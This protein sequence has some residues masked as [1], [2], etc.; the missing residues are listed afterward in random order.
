MIG[1]I[2]RIAKTHPFKF[3]M[4]YSLL[5]TAGCD[6][7]VQKVV[8]KREEVDWKRTLAFGSFG[9]FYLGGVQYAIY[10]PLFSR[11]F[12]NAAAFSAKTIAEKAKDIPGIR[13]VCAQVF[14][15]QCV[16]HPLMYFPVFYMLKD[17]ITSEKPDPA[18]AVQ[19]YIG[20]AREDLAALWK[21]WIPSTFINFAFMPM[22]GRIPWVASTSLIWTC[23]LSA[24]RGGADEKLPE[25]EPVF[26]GVDAQTLALVTRWIIGPAPRLDPN[27]AHFLVSVTGDD[28]P[29][30]IKEITRALYTAGGSITTSKMMSLGSEMSITM[31]VECAPD[32]E[33]GVQRALTDKVLTSDLG[34]EIITRRVEPLAPEQKQVPA[35]SGLVSVTGV[36]RPGLVYR[37]TDLLSHHGL[38]IEHLQTEQHR[39]RR[40][41][42]PPVFTTHCHIASAAPTD[43]SR[44]REA[45]NSLAQELELT[46]KF[47]VGQGVEITNG[48]RLPL[49]RTVTG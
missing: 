17:A 33:V 23:I 43:T 47:E 1:S 49:H 21:I 3:G 25:G 38:N 42:S 32:R 24:M 4:G 39:R 9:L 16:H 44:L 37:L 27:H 48:R 22:W 12:P 2:L 20:N 45:L 19:K 41:N 7:M 13:N 40:Q 29:G 11:L 31:H 35:F 46:L 28:K 34:L 18:N 15:D 6:L 36:D 26:A 30:L 14:L 8:E 10:V 5:K